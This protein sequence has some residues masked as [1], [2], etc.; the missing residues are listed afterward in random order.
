MED[1]VAKA[2]ASGDGRKRV[3]SRIATEAVAV[4]IETAKDRG[5]AREHRRVAFWAA[6]VL[7]AIVTGAALIALLAPDGLIDG[8]A[9]NKAFFREILRLIVFFVA[10]SVFGVQIVEKFSGGRLDD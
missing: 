7:L 5:V 2:M 6:A 10:A 3:M 4:D 9:E 1:G 8:S